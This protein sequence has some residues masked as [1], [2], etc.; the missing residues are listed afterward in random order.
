MVVVDMGKRAIT[1]EQISDDEWVL[2]NP[3]TGQ[4]VGVID[5]QGLSGL[6]LSESSLKYIEVFTDDRRVNREFQVKDGEIFFRPFK[7]YGK[8]NGNIFQKFSELGLTDKDFRFFLFLLSCVS[9]NN[10]YVKKSKRKTMDIDGVMQGLN[11]G[12]AMAYR[13]IQRAKDFEIIKI[14]SCG[15]M[16]FNPF[17]YYRNGRSISK[18]AY[19]LFK[20]TFWKDV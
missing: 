12:K 3:D 14:D 13:L 11:I 19:S 10:N 4:Q 5:R 9:Q 20:N 16:V 2:I 7:R 6:G 1:A 15:K 17:I 18:T 8:I